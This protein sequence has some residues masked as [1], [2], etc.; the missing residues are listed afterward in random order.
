MNM[1]VVTGATGN[2]GRPLVEALAAAGHAVTAVSRG[3]SS[4]LP[5]RD[6]VRPVVADL[7]EPETLKPAF[8]GAEELFLL[9]SGAGS[10]VD[11]PSVLSLARQAGVER[12]VLL[13]SQA[14]GTRPG[15][16][17]H[18]PLA[19]I[20]EAVQTS[21]LAWTILRP[22]GFNTNAFAW[23]PTIADRDAAFAP[24]ADVALPGVDPLDIAGVAAAVLHESPHHGQTYVLTGPEATSPRQRVEAISAAIGRPLTFHELT[25]D[26]ARQQMVRFMPE[27]VADGTLAILGTPTEDEQR[28]SADIQTILGRPAGT[29]AAWAQ[30]NAGIFR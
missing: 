24:F 14:V 15:S 7:C 30:R 8:E 1:I 6:G 29:F 28:V 13:S 19:A 3:A 11:A 18:A 22:G 27:P 17:S 25:P 10:H 20:E 12:V 9:V 21:G 4:P 26:E 2:V 23:A 16:Q 5:S